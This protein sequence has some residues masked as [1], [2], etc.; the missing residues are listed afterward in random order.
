MV[1]HERSSSHRRRTIV[2]WMLWLLV[3]AAIAV[4]L[5][6]VAFG[7]DPR[8]FLPGPS[9]AGHHQIEQDCAACHAPDGRVDEDRCMTC[10]RAE[11]TEALD[12]HP[13]TKFSDPR[14]ADRLVG[15]DAMR[16][17]TCHVEHRPDITHASGVT[18]PEDFCAH[19]HADIGEQRESHRDLPFTG[20]AAAGCH[21]YHDNRILNESFI[22]RHLGQP[23]LL[24]TPRM[25]DRDALARWIARQEPTRPVAPDAPPEHDAP[26]VH[27]DWHASGHA[28]AGVSCSDCHERDRTGAVSPWLAQPGH[29]ACVRCH[30]TEVAGWLDGKHGM[31]M[32][33]G[34]TPMTTDQSR[35]AMAV[36]AH[37]TLDCSSCHAAHRYD[38][39]HAQVDACLTCHADDHSRAYL[40]SPHH[41]TWLAAVAAGDPAAGVSCATCHLPRVVTGSGDE[42]HVRVEHDQNAHL[43]PV[44]TMG[45]AVCLNCHGLEYTLD[46]LAEP[47][48][49]QANFPTPPSTR[50]PG[51]DWVRSRH[52]APPAAVTNPAETPEPSEGT[53]P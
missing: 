18:L 25:P 7:E 13:R 34:L 8:F 36:A 51:P 14:E 32:A 40:G 1:S 12:A 30:Q 44:E 35:L 42:R 24:P 28:Q 53:S 52:D 31:R 46:A 48:A 21:N 43:R 16:C 19:C 10:H 33:R 20:C 22:A 29:D 27:A 3:V 41:R 5:A 4:R 37:R 45:R 23:A 15:L 50:A 39:V 6:N 38:T 11:L 17:V 47:G 2:I 49:A 9:T 26:H